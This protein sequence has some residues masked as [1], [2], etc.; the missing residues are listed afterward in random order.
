MNRRRLHPQGRHPDRG[1][2]LPARL[3]LQPVS[4]EDGSSLLD[5][6]NKPTEQLCQSTLIKSISYQ[7]RNCQKGPAKLHSRQRARPWKGFWVPRR[8]HR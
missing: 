6:H 5:G 2:E 4:G 3:A 1:H 7:G 8:A